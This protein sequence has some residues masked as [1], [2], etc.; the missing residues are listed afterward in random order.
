MRRT[1]LVT[2]IVALALAGCAPASSPSSTLPASTPLGTQADRATLVGDVYDHRVLVGYRWNGDVFATEAQLYAA[3]DQAIARDREKL[4][5]PVSGGG[6]VTVLRPNPRAV[7]GVSQGANLRLAEARIEA[8][9]NSGLFSAVR[10][11]NDA[12]GKFTARGG[13]HVLR[14]DQESWRLLDGQDR[15]IGVANGKDLVQFV[16]NVAQ[17]AALLRGD[18]D[19]VHALG[20]VQVTGAPDVVV[21]QDRKY[22]DL[23][24]LTDALDRVNAA[25]TAQV[26]PTARPLGGKVLVVMPRHLAEGASL[27]PGERPGLIDSAR[28]AYRQALDRRFARFVV[29]SKLFAEVRVDQADS[30]GRVPL[31]YDWVLW[32]DAASPMWSARSR[33]MELGRF[34][35]P[36][37]PADFTALLA[38]LLTL[39][40]DLGAEA[41]V[42][43]PE[44]SAV[45]GGWK[46]RGRLFDDVGELDAAMARRLG[47]E[48]EDIR[49]AADSGRTLRVVL[50]DPVAEDG[51]IGRL[52]HRLDLA[53][54][55]GLRRSALVGEPTVETAPARDPGPEGHDF[56]LYRAGKAW[57]IKDGQGRV[58][59]LPAMDAVRDFVGG[60][61]RAMV[62]LAGPLD[63]LAVV[64][65]AAGVVYGF[66]GREFAGLRG[67]TAEF[68]QRLEQVGRQVVAVPPLAAR[69]LVVLPRDSRVSQAEVDALLAAGM[70]VQALAGH[71]A[72]RRFH[73]RRVAALVAASGL[74]QAVQVVTSAESEP[75]QGAY[76]WV[77]WRRPGEAEWMMRAQGEIALRVAMPGSADGFALDLRALMTQGR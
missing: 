32:R 19:F 11:E 6:A 16:A 28:K 48:V 44:I 29:A 68:E 58:L 47:A 45:G 43:P 53:R 25:R 63:D 1:L 51:A 74:F 41:M 46:W 4:P 38:R 60:V 9:R 64:P 55:E 73:D 31:D 65:V 50:P 14:F 3:I 56:V 39:P 36:V 49:P 12:P 54:V 13:D 77:I 69:A 7:V 42:D 71:H 27:R 67:L 10:V 33:D 76:D 66:G 18:D 24:S 17:A 52:S 21:Y 15:H 22:T 23:V 70:P 59:R 62:A 5:R 2:M 40:P 57:R 75:A 35:F 34:G 72:L 61:E 26:V 30:L 20:F 37:E 8:L